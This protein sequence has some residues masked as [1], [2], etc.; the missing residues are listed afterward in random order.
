[1]PRHQKLYSLHR[2]A[3]QVSGPLRAQVMLAMPSLLLLPLLDALLSHLLWAL[4]LVTLAVLL[5]TAEVSE[6]TLLG[7]SGAA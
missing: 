1:M 4:L 5:S 3:L 2:F 7:I 6:L